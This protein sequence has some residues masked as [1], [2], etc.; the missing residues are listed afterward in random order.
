MNEL[1]N[2]YIELL[3]KRCINF[4]KTNSLFINYDKVNKNFVDKLIIKAKEMGVND[5]A[6][7]EDDIFYYHDK[8]RDIDIKDIENDSY[9]DKSLWDMY[10]EKNAA[11]L[12]FDTE[13]PGIMDDIDPKKIEAARSAKRKTRTLFREKETTY[14]IPWCIAALPNEIW[15]KNIFPDSNDSYNDLFKVI[16]KMCMVDT[17]NPIESWNEYLKFSKNRVEILND[18]KIMKLHYKNQLGTNLNITLPDNSKWTS[19]ADDLKDDMFVNMPSFEIF[20]TPDYRKTEGIVYSSK[21][22]YYG[23][24]IIE[25]F[26]IRFKNGKVIDFNAEKGYELLKEIIESDENAC[27]LGEV[28]LVEYDSPISNTKLIFGTTLFDENASCHLA[29]GDGFPNCVENGLNMS[30]KELLEIG[31]NQSKNHVDFMIGT[32]DLQIEAETSKGKILIF[33]NGNFSINENID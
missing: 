15:A 26:N 23:G 28:A 17:K 10:A 2:K 1:E 27:Y 3:L 24:G 12:I 16:C 22:L 18:L 6:I 13:F 19:A 4:K 14:Q 30:E 8:L 21:P 33:K 31:V 7:D 25:N 11:F 29:L 5:I 32:E 20:T 9:F